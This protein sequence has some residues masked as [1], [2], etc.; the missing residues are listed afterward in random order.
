MKWRL[1]STGH[2]YRRGGKINAIMRRVAQMDDEETRLLAAF[3]ADLLKGAG[4]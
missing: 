3:I 4:E 2:T 1:I